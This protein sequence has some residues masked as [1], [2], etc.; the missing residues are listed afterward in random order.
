MLLMKV[1]RH[2]CAVSRSNFNDILTT[3]QL[4]DRE[5]SSNFHTE[6]KEV[7]STQVA[8]LLIVL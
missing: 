4:C 1:N 2:P 3:E 6:V 5:R 8:A 7:V